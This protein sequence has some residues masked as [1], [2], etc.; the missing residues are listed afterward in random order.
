MSAKSCLEIYYKETRAPFFVDFLEARPGHKNG[1][2]T[3]KI[4]ESDTNPPL[5][6]YFRRKYRQKN[7]ELNSGQTTA[8]AVV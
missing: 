6:T 5:K 7:K 3:Y 1:A 8:T 4:K 2:V